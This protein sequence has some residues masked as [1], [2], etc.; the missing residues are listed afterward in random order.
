MAIDTNCIAQRGQT[1]QNKSAIGTIL[2]AAAVAVAGVNTA[3]AI[4]IAD[5]QWDIANGYLS[6]SK[7][8]R[9]YYNNV[10]VPW[11]NAEVDEVT[12]YQLYDPQYDRAMGR[13]ANTAWYL[14]QDRADRAIEGI[15]SYCAGLRA[16]IIKDEMVVEAQIVSSLT[17]MG[18]RNERAY[19]D[20]LDDRRWKRRE[21]VLNRGRGLLA[22]NIAFANLA[23]GIL[24]NLGAQA[25][26]AAGSALY[27]LGYRNERGDMVYGAA[28]TM[29]EAAKVKYGNPSTKLKA[30]TVE[31]Y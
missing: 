9:N 2:N 7:D 27:Y 22:N 10:Y 16:A 28:G 4:R 6:I 11:E 13:H 25:G 30:T 3:A 24:G 17:N 19:K 26:D 23:A 15:S 21:Q 12:A 1:D 31:A 20:A 5:M 29:E 14:L 18:Y 8:W